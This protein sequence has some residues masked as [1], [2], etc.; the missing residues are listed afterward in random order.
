MWPCRKIHLNPN[1][2]KKILDGLRDE[3]GNADNRR[4]DQLQ[5]LLVSE[6]IRIADLLHAIYPDMSHTNAQD[7]LRQFRQTINRAAQEKGLV[8]RFEV[9]TKKRTPPAQRWCWFEGEDTT[10]LEIEAY[11]AQETADSD[12]Q[13]SIKPKAVIHGKPAHSIFCQLR[14][15]R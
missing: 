12:A 2:V 7:R 3:L 11:S 13:T 8:F 10:I 6:Q 9:D 14:Q 5:E 1:Q 15:Q 4:I